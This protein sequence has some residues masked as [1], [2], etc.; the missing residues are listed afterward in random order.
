[1]TFQ[2]SE[3]SNT[4]H[5][6]L[7]RQFVSGPANAPGTLSGLIR[8]G[9]AAFDAPEAANMTLAGALW[10]STGDSAVDRAGSMRFAADGFIDAVPSGWQL[11]IEMDTEMPF[12]AGDHLVVELGFL[13]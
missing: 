6:G 11:T 8:I 4:D 10:V 13:S 1:V 7:L 3:S 2:L 12:Q 9:F 5:Y